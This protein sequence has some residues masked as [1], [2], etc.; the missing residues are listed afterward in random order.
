MVSQPSKCLKF[1]SFREGCLVMSN[2]MHLIISDALET[3]LTIS[4]Q[5]I[6]ED[7]LNE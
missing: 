5:K 3:F 7:K 1:K 6:N 2:G 4:L